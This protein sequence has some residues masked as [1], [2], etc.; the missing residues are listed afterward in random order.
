MVIRGL[1]MKNDKLAWL[2]NNKGQID[3]AGK[4][5]NKPT[6]IDK[7]KQISDFLPPND[8]SNYKG[9]I[10]T[11]NFLVPNKQG[12]EFIRVM[13]NT[14][15]KLQSDKKDLR[16]SLHIKVPQTTYKNLMFLTNK[17]KLNNSETIELLINEETDELNKAIKKHHRDIERLKSKHTQ[18]ILKIREKYELEDTVPKAIHDGVKDELNKTKSVLV[19]ISEAITQ[20]K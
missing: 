13:A 9:I 12:P 15:T 10:K 1:K 11:L 6:V 16:K 2:K 17:N 8:H 5:F 7:M 20:L 14:W 3:W 4:Y 19:K 18:D